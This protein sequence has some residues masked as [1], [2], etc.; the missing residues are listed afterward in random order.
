MAGQNLAVTA[1]YRGLAAVRVG[2]LEEAVAHFRLS[3]EYE[4][5]Y[6]KAHYA[7]GK[8]RADLGDFAGAEADLGTAIGLHADFADALVMRG[9]LLA[10]RQRRDAALA[11][12]RRALA[13]P[14][15]S[16]TLHDQA[17]ELVGILEL[18]AGQRNPLG[19]VAGLFRRLPFRRG[20]GGL[21]PSPGE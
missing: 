12:L 15:C 4:P 8:A 2:R 7:L 16:P 11:D 19:V 20:A 17:A 10:R 21:R 5:G 9:F 1:Y 13:L 6:A 18:Q 3:T 14:R